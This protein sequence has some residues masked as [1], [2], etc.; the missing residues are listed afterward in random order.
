MLASPRFSVGP[1]LQGGFCILKVMSVW[2]EV[3]IS[4]NLLIRAEKCGDE[5]FL[6]VICCLEKWEWRS[7]CWKM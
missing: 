6:E 5:A 1:M 7:V 4:S 3:E 2:V